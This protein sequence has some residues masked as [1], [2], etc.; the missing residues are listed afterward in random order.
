M[1]TPNKPRRAKKAPLM[2][3]FTKLHTVAGYARLMG[4]HRA[5]IYLHIK[6]GLIK[7]GQILVCDGQAMIL[8]E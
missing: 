3:D 1:Q 2:I 6:S 8:E 7:P 4:T 5:T